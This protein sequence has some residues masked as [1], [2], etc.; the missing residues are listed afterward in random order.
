MST[1]RQADTQGLDPRPVAGQSAADDRTVVVGVDGSPESTEA[2]RYA[3]AAAQARGMWLLVVHAYE[4]PPHRSTVTASVLAAAARTA[5]Y[6]VTAD[7]MSGVPIPAGV[8][9]EAA[10]ELTTPVLMLQRLSGQVAMIVLGQ[11]ADDPSDSVLAGP[12]TSSVAAVASCPVVLVPAGWSRD[13]YPSRSI[14]VGWDGRPG[15]EVVLDYAFTEAERRGWPL[16]ALHALPIGATPLQGSVESE[17][18]R[19][20]ISGPRD[21]HPGVRASAVVVQGKFD[22]VMLS[23]SR[24]ARLLVVGRPARHSRPGTWPHSAARQV[25][26]RLRCPLVVVPQSDVDPTGTPYES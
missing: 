19:N 16:L 10:V 17:R 5:A 24:T 11:H 20:I 8:E 4:L 9:V 15:A 12:L 3:A 26:S 2:L 25:M 6:R 1:G 13:T 21:D 23:A 7:A 14:V 18:L 22:R